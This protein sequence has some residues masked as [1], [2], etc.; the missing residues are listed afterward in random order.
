MVS[1]IVVLIWAAGSWWVISNENRETRDEPVSYKS[2]EGVN[3]YEV[4]KLPVKTNDLIIGMSGGGLIGGLLVWEGEILK[5]SR[6]ELKKI[7]DYVVN[8]RWVR[9]IGRL[10]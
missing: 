4:K 2:N 8:N 3:L 9:F 6:E 7:A 5:G 1:L 10:L